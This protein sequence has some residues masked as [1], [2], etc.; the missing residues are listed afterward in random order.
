MG[1]KISYNYNPAIELYERELTHPTQW[2]RVTQK[3][4]WF[5]LLV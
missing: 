5:S 4:A 1:T 2:G 3:I